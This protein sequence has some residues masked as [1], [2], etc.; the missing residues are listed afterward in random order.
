MR[1]GF[2]DDFVSE[3]RTDRFRRKLAA[4]AISISC[5]LIVVA[6]FL[7][8]GNETLRGQAS[9]SLDG[10]GDDGDA[11]MPPIDLKLIKARSEARNAIDAPTAQ[12]PVPASD[13]MLPSVTTDE[14][15]MVETVAPKNETIPPSAAMPADTVADGKTHADQNILDQI[16]RCLPPGVRPSLSAKLD[17]R[18]DAT[19]NLAAAP[20]LEWVGG[21]GSRD[22]IAAENAVVQ[23]ALQCGPY[24]VPNG[25]GSFA[26]AADFSKS[27]AL[28]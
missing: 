14:P 17:L 2:W 3:A 9:H 21:Q 28:Q 19:G 11:A 1:S 6:A 24:V 4:A 18:L 7:W 22:A 12:M 23:A 27:F 20:Q 10:A 25:A 8:S 15:T 13:A 16:A 26:I 5:H